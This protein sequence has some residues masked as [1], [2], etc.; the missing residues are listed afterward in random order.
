[1]E[2]HMMAAKR[3]LRYIRAT[4]DLGVFYRKGCEDEMLAYTDSDYAGDLDDRKSTSGYV[5]MLSGG[6]V[7][8]SSKKQ[9]VVTLSTTEAEF[10]AAASCACQCIWLQ[11]ILKQI[12]GTERKCVKVLCDNSSTIKLAKNPVLH[13][14]SKHIDVRFHFLRNLTKD[15]V[16][17]IEH[18]GTNEQLADIMTKPLRLE[19]FEKFRAA[20]GVNS[21]EE[22]N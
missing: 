22:I 6:A 14:R 1:M 5:F 15:E 13:G 10:V 19:L 8:W 18:C 9:P 12:G 20:L 4:T 7:A 11:Q 16:I 21:A 3:I 17:D 2:S